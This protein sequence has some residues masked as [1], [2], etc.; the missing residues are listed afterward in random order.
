MGNIVT[1]NIKLGNRIYKLTYLGII[2]NKKKY[3]QEVI[4]Y[5]QNR[6]PDCGRFLSKFTKENDKCKECH[7]KKHN[8]QKKELYYKHRENTEW[9][10]KERERV[11]KYEK[12]KREKREITRLYGKL[13]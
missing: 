10:K 7:R 13:W 5:I 12:E 2:N 3:K 6:C 4:S 8:K 11:K 1:S 9:V